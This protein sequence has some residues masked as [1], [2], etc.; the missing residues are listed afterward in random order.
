M[1]NTDDGI[2]CAGVYA[3]D[4]D[5]C[6]LCNRPRVEH[7]DDA[8]DTLLVDVTGTGLVTGERAAQ[9]EGVITVRGEVR[10]CIT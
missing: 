8:P 5:I 4:D 1:T 10:Q 7:D 6:T 9:G 2:T 3:D